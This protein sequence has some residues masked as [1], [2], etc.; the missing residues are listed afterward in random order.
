VER[1]RH[2]RRPASAVPHHQMPPERRRQWIVG[3]VLGVLFGAAVV[4]GGPWV[5]ARMF[6]APA[7]EPLEV[8]MPDPAVQAE[9]A[10]PLDIAGTWTVAEGSQAGY[11]VNEVLNG[12]PVEVVGR[13]DMVSGTSTVVDGQVTEAV[14]TVQTATITTDEA[15]RDAYFERA[16]DTSTYPE[17]TFELTTPVDIS[18][19][20]TATDPIE[21]EAPG[22]LTIGGTTTDVIAQLTLQQHGAGVEVAGQIPVTID[23]MGVTPPD[24]PFVTVDPNASIELLLILTH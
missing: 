13:T 1:Q 6:V 7:P 8:T 24:L 10:E 5:Y 23:E 12:E 18:A 22:R 15:A 19:I 16:L 4:T 21:A 9:P 14:V 2:G 17:A 11:R 20:D 3:T